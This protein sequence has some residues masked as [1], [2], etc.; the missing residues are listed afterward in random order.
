VSFTS[1]EE[2]YRDDSN[3]RARIDLHARFSVGPNWFEW[4]WEREAPPP[5]ARLL[6]IGCGPA[7]LW[8]VVL[9]RV[10]PTVS[11]TLSDFSPGMIDAARAVVG[12]RA[13]Y[14]VADVQELPFADESFD[15]VIANH[16]LY[17]VAD[18]PK[19]LAE[20]ARVLVPGG[21]FHAST[22]ARGHL[23][24]LQALAPDWEFSGHSELFGLE[25]GAEQIAQVFADVRVERCDRR[26]DVT[27]V[28]PI[29]AYIR[30]SNT[31]RGQD[32]EPARATVEAA[33]ERDGVYRI[34]ALPGVVSARKP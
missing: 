18:R 3:L 34:Q 12:D 24:E 6:E 25:T 7:E 26:L 16:M 21:S 20:I 29:L 8:K 10:E 5:G 32:L 1:V 13:D 23:D 22:N 19:A 31:Y 2:Q 17:H 33:L 27:E 15:V 4:L 28:E 11:L 14:V 30:S 9:D